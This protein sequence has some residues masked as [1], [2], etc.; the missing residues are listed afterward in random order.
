MP[1]ADGFLARSQLCGAPDLNTLP[2]Q[3]PALS[4][5]LS[6]RRRWHRT[7]IQDLW[8]GS[9]PGD[10]LAA[11]RTRRIRSV[12]AVQKCGVHDEIGYVRL[13]VTLS[14]VYKLGGPRGPISAGCDAAEH[15]QS[16]IV[17]Q[18]P[19][20]L[21]DRWVGALAARGGHRFHQH[22][23]VQGSAGLQGNDRL[24]DERRVGIG[25]RVSAP[26]G[27]AIDRCRV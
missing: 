5:L 17:V 6:G 24:D 9:A 8:D 21:G 25:L 20:Q 11:L 26:S 14:P 3:R 22:V 15:S 1:Q 19:P 16:V 12:C 23:C 2:A 7:L 18:Q 13:P 10:A 4:P 27:P